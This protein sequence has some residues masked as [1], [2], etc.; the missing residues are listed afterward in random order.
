MKLYC[1]FDITIGSYTGNVFQQANNAS[2]IRSCKQAMR[3]PQTTLAQ[4]PQDYELWELGEFHE[5]TG[6]ITPNKQRV[7]R[8]SDINEQEAQ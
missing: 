5:V 2:A 7:C 1:M 4:Y 3:D 6:D 8:L